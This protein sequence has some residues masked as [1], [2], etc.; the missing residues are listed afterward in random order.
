VLSHR[1]VPCN[2][3]GLALGQATIAAAAILTG[4]CG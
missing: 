2:D 3:G 1:T 4:R